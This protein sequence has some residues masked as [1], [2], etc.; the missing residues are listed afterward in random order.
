MTTRR[1]TSLTLALWQTPFA[2]DPALA[3]QRL[4]VAAAQARAGGADLLLTPEMSL[5]GYAIGA[6]AVRDRA[7]PV[8]GPLAQAVAALARRH[9]IALVVGLA[10]RHPHGQAPYNTALAFGPDGALLARYRKVHLFGDMDRAQFSPGDAGSRVWHWRGWRFGLLICFDVEFAQTV[11]A[12]A[13]QGVDAVLVPTA[14]M[15]EYDEVPLQMV[16]ER[17]RDNGV[18][19]AYANACG[20]EGPLRY[21][22]LSTVAGPDG[23][24]AVRA[25]RETALQ[26]VRLSRPG[27]R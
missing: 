13:Q 12:L 27:G 23:E 9:G 11:R 4:D 21:G 17:A 14:N 2:A 15:S 26:I 19:V 3:L 10:E 8:D 5:C 20:D 25:G 24:V 6:H 1:D 16:P 18:W 22:G 7:E